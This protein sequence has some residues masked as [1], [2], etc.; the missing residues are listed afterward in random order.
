MSRAEF[1]TDSGLLVLAGTPIGDAQ[2]ASPA[3]VRALTTA[4]VI[5]AE[6]TRALRK[7]LLRL[8]VTTDAPVVSYFEGNE[9]SRIPG[10]VAATGW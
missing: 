8:G 3:L 7:L 2:D 5:A 9:A 1:P 6:D 4:D 10:L